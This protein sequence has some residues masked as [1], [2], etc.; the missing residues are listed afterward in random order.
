MSGHRRKQAQSAGL[1]LQVGR[2]YSAYIYAIS[3]GR[4]VMNY[5]MAV[6]AALV[7]LEKPT[8]P[9]ITEKTGISGQRVNGALNNLREILGLAISRVGSNKTG[10]Y[11][12]DAWGAFESGKHILRK[13]RALDLDK[14]KQYRVIHYNQALLKKLYS[15]DVKLGN[16]RQSLALEGIP[17]AGDA[18]D[19]TQL[20]AEE[21]QAL[22]E[23]LKNKYRRRN[24]P[25]TTQ[26]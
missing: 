19:L 6:L 21:R 10:H 15:D 16:Y 18:P 4:V 1:G 9:S 8:K 5:E 3:G 17:A 24:T 12:I 22:R 23:K 26:V 2:L 20:S 7:Q 11:Q 14:Y 13:A 25:G